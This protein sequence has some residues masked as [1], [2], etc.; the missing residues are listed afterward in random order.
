M[1]RAGWDVAVYEC[2]GAE[3]AGRNAAGL[4]HTTANAT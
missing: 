4:Q 2:N 1:R 3:L